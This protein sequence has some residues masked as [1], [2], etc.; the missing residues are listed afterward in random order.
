PHLQLT[1]PPG[2]YFLKIKTQSE[3]KTEKLVVLR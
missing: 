3:T 1:L 2:I